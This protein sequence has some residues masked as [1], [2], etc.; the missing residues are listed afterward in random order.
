MCIVTLSHICYST[1]LDLYSIVIFEDVRS[2]QEVLDRRALASHE[3]PL[4]ALRKST[5]YSQLFLIHI[6][7][8][9]AIV[10]YGNRGIRFRRFKLM[11][12]FRLRR[13]RNWTIPRLRRLVLSL[14]H[15]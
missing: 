15:I 10:G 8:S 5:S 9:I 3:T 13:F 7:K 12:L 11:Q 6:L 14:I 1:A 2:D 4:V